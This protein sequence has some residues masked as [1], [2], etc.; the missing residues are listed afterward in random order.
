MSPGQDKE[1]AEDPELAAVRERMRLQAEQVA[2]LMDM[3]AKCVA[4]G[5]DPQLAEQRMHLCERLLWKH[6]RRLMQLQAA[7]ADAA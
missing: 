3:V 5:G 7:R 1:L 4:S 6:H 2:H